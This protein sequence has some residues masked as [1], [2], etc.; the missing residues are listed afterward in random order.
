[1]TCPW[2]RILIVCVVA[3]TDVIV[4]IYDIYVVGRTSTPVSY[5]AHISGAVTGLLVGITFLKNLRWQSHERV[6][7]VVSLLVFGALMLVAIVWNIAVPD[8]F[9]GL[10]VPVPECI[11]QAIF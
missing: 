3:L 1:M 8:H 2:C 11:S 6:I 7:W 4:Y 5:P 10:N 9:T